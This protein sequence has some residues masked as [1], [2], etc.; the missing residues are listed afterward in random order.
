M[1]ALGEVKLKPHYILLEEHYAANFR[2]LVKSVARL[3]GSWQNAEDAVQEAYASALKYGG[4]YP[5]EKFDAWIG[6]IVHNKAKKMLRDAAACGTTVELDDDHLRIEERSEPFQFTEEVNNIIDSF[7]GEDKVILRW[8]FVEGY[9]VEE[10]LPLVSRNRTNLWGF[11][12][13]FLQR[14]RKEV[15]V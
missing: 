8:Y 15:V 7:T 5:T 14:V 3:A 6:T 9:T 11:L 13:R 12:K 4:K 2:R 10:I 1:N